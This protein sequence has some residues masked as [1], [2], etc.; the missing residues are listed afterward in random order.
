[1]SYVIRGEKIFNIFNIYDYGVDITARV[2]VST[3]ELVGI[4]DPE[5]LKSINFLFV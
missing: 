1:M 5:W 4:D 3:G 2:S